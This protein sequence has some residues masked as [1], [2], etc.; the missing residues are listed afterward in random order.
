MASV[1]LL[2]MQ[3]KEEVNGPAWRHTLPFEV[4]KEFKEVLGLVLDHQYNVDG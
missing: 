1:V 2:K 4:T 3:N